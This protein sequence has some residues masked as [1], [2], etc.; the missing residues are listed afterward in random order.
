MIRGPLSL[1][2]SLVAIFVHSEL[3]AFGSRPFSLSIQSAT[4]SSQVGMFRSGKEMAQQDQEKDPQHIK[5]E[6]G[7]AWVNTAGMRD[8]SLNNVEDLKQGITSLSSSSS[9]VW[10]LLLPS[11]G[12]LAAVLFAKYSGVSATS[13]AIM[14]SFQSN[15]TGTVKTVFTGSDPSTIVYFGF[16]YVIAELIAI[17]ATPLTL[18][19][20][21]L[22]GLAKGIAVVLVAGVI[23]AIV[24]FFVGRTYLRD[25]VEGVLDDKPAFRKLDSAIG[26]EGL[27]LLVLVRLT[28]I[29]PFSLLNYFYGASSISFPTFVVGTILGFIPSAIAYVYAGLV[30]KELI[31]GGA[32]QPWYIYVGVVTVLAGFLKLVTDV[33]TSLIDAVD[34]AD[35][36]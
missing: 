21:C 1:L 4:T 22:F 12:A 19:A 33:A 11:F 3:K 9:R 2:C 29:F 8:L 23:S 24:G 16:F 18:S 31:L 6:N 17:P 5:I 27:K 20:G 15:P 13:L 32:S 14:K 35:K 25:R 36:E 30:G 7:K 26:A 34:E 28:P 10:D